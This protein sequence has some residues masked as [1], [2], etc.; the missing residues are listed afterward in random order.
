MAKKDDDFL[1]ELVATFK[2]EAQEHL[3]ALSSGVLALEKASTAEEQRETLEIVFREA[4]SL[5]GAARAVNMTGIESLCQALETVF[6]ALKRHELALSASLF[7]ELHQAI[8]GL[9]QLLL[10]T[11]TGPEAAEPSRIRERIQ[12]LVQV[13]QGMLPVP[14]PEISRAAAAVPA[15]EVD[16]RWDKPGLGETVRISTAKLDAVLRQAEE[17]L[18]TK[19]AAGQR[20]AELRAV[21]A[22]MTTWEREWAKICSDVRSLQQ[23]FE[24]N[25]ENPGRSALGETRAQMRLLL[26]FLQWN[27]TF[28]K[29]LER[30]LSALARAGQHDHQALGRRVDELLEDMKN[31][32]MLPFSSLLAS[33]PKLVRA[34]SRDRGK[35]V[36]LVISG[37]EIEID[38]RILEEIKDPLMHLV[39]NCID[40]GIEKPE[41]RERKQKPPCGKVTL[42]ITLKD[43]SKVEILVADDGVG[44]DPGRVKSAA[45]RMGMM[46]P[47]EMD[48]L[49][50]PEAL[51]LIFQSG[52]STSPFITHISG[53]GLGLAIVQEKL[54]N[55]G[56]VITLDTHPDGGT[57]FRLVVPM[58]LATF[59][60]VLVRVGESPFI[61][62][63][64]HVERVARVK[65]EDIQTVENRETIE[66]GGC[67]VSLVQLE[68]VLGLPRHG[69]TGG[70]TESMPAV[71]LSSADKRIA[72]LVTEVLNV[73]EVLAKGLGKQLSRVSNMAGASVLGTG[74]VVPILNVRDLMKS[75]VR[76]SAG[77]AMAAPLEEREEKRQNILV[78]E[79]SITARTL[80]KGILEAAGYGVVTAV[81][82]EHGSEV[83][84]NAYIVK[85]RFDQSD[86]LA[87]IR[88]LI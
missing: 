67:A 68:D 38:R 45:V 42:A 63:A 17:L 49:S 62:P 36:E 69:S 39:R 5:K 70:S 46:T 79:D 88:R 85:S 80:L 75:A 43:S 77:T 64:S 74:E 34:P 57:T 84:A 71:V 44:I 11:E 21:H 19:L 81:D 76:A 52:V 56:G 60:G 12:R 37:E 61:L 2:I 24:R 20:A 26:E 14:E 16:H 48:I 55:L 3:N 87:V 65:P 23:S 33:F 30:Q 83:G 41:E 8:D 6:A 32:L 78:V 27:S 53:R 40:H 9:G 51:A 25:G 29:K 50:T 72:F 22:G 58:T 31:V 18:S 35:E 82:R 7:D 66:L 15:A 4:H 13:S 86:L 28:L 47:Q 10:T 73:Q 1:K 54:E 59:Q